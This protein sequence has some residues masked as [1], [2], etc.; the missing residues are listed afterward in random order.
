MKKD[1][2]WVRLLSIPKSFYVSWRL[3]DFKT[4]LKLPVR[5]KYNSILA[6]LK[7]KLRIMDTPLSGGLLYIG[8]YSSGISDKRYSRALLEIDGEII[9]DGLV[10]FGQGTKLIVGPS[11]RLC[12][13]KG[14][15]STAE[16]TFICYKEITIGHDTA[17]AWYAMVMDTD[18][19]SVENTQ[20]GQVYP[21]SSKIQIGEHCWLGTRSVTLKGSV[22]PNG[23]ILAA[24][25]T[26]TKVFTN[27][28]TL[29]AGCPA[30]EKKHNVTKSTKGDIL[31]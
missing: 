1:N 25:S 16:G 10:Q 26:A 8:F 5:V 23:C 22:I 2:R 27:K 3:T 31:L 12:L 28:D 11:G 30:I 19:H 6:S 20:T 21:A 29:L 17:A 18:F 13:G 24:N 15:S 9:I 14:F 4:A 7:G